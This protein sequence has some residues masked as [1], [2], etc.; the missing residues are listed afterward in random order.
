MI[1]S[2][3][4]TTFLGQIVGSDIPSS[5]VPLPVTFQHAD[6]CH[7]E[8]T[9]FSGPEK[10][11]VSAGDQYDMDSS[12]MPVL[13]ENIG[14]CGSGSSENLDFLLDESFFESLDNLP[15]GDE[16]FIEANDEGFIEANDLSNP[17][18]T[19]T[20]ALDMLEEYLTYFDA[21]DDSSLY[22]SS[23][24]AMMLNNE[25]LF[26]GQTLLPQKVKMH[27]GILCFL[28]SFWKRFF[29]LVFFI[30]FTRKWA[31]H[32]SKLFCQ[33]DNSLT[34][35]S[36]MLYHLVISLSWQNINQ[37]LNATPDLITPVITYCI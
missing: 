4:C 14:E 16:G 22:F 5:T 11:L 23:D 17:S 28:Y 35:I 30:P 29:N 37:V 6:G 32:P 10:P 9:T 36:I 27:F 18:E 7:V 20:A 33:V 3:S 8:E 1:I 15:Y 25:D 21:N 34:I 26:S 19:D 2:L 24:S 13:S 31:K 12:A